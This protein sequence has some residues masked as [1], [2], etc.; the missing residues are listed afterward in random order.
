VELL[1]SYVNALNLQFASKVK[2]IGRVVQAFSYCYISLLVVL[3]YQ[4][5]LMPLSMIEGM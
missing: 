1:Q 2:Q 4:M 3:I 5:M